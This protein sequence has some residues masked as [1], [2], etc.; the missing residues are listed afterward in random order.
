MKA[1]VLDASLT[2]EWF[3]SGASANAVAK[4]GLFEDRVAVVPHLWRFE[5]MNVLATWRRR[6][7]ISS[8]QGTRI[9]NSALTLPFAVIDEGNAEAV[10][11][12][13]NAHG[14]SAY[15]ATYLRVAIVTGEPLASL[16]QKLI[17][18]AGKEGI[19]CL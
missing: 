15:D 1:F 13:A 3:S 14:L 19:E 5:V 12:L 4:R 17:N 6:G 11:E 9:L 8:A 2:M 7:D 16:D 10:V 18:A